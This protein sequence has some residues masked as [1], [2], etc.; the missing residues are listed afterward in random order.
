MGQFIEGNLPSNSNQ[1]IRTRW[2]MCEGKLKIV[3]GWPTFNRRKTSNWSWSLDGIKAARSAFHFPLVSNQLLTFL[4]LT[5]V[6]GGFWGGW[7]G[8]TNTEVPANRYPK[9][10]RQQRIVVISLQLKSPSPSEIEIRWWS[11]KSAAATHRNNKTKKKMVG[12]SDG[13]IKEIGEKL[14]KQKTTN[15]VWHLDSD[16]IPGKHFI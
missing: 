13:S 2:V 1:L 4:S 8:A 15:W 5:G 7:D 9:Q 12:Q 10:F 16:A 6:S 3:I 14:E 11:G